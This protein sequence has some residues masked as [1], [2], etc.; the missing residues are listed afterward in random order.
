[1]DQFRREYN[2][3]EIRENENAKLFVYIL[4]IIFVICFSIFTICGNILCIKVLKHTPELHRG[5]KVFMMSLAMSDLS[6]GF[7]GSLSIAPAILGFWPFGKVLCKMS[8]TLGLAICGCSVLSLCLL[9]LDRCLA[10]TQPLRHVSLV[11]KKRAL[12]LTAFIWILSFGVVIPC[13]LDTQVVYNKTAALCLAS[14]EDESYLIMVVMMSLFLYFIPMVVMIATY[15]KLLY[16]SRRHAKQICVMDS[17]QIATPR[18][19]VDNTGVTQER[20]AASNQA[21]IQPTGLQ[22]PPANKSRYRQSLTSLSTKYGRSMKEW[23]ALKMFCTVTM[24][25]TI[26]WIPYVCTKL[27]STIRNECTPGW[28]EF[29]VQ[30]LALCNSWCNV[31]IY[32]LM[33]LSFRNTAVRLIKSG[34]ASCCM[35]CYERFLQMTEE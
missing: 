14:M 17:I 32:L 28:V 31:C 1:M 12:F 16:I 30:W 24:V 19:S 20:N 29:L 2:E 26:T 4:R 22:S 11:T 13:S 25:F 21:N 15:S 3:T 34:Q 10:V 6:V 5:T 9:T 7:L 23:K 27:I 18:S 35:C 33:N 8:C